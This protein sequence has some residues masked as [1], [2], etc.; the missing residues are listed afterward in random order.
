MIRHQRQA[1]I[2]FT[3]LILPAMVIFGCGG[4]NNTPT[5]SPTCM[6]FTPAQAPAAGFV[7]PQVDAASTCDILVLNMMVTDVDDLFGGGALLSF[8]TNLM[9]YT[10]ISSTGSTLLQ[11]GVAVEVAGDRPCPDAGDNWCRPL[12]QFFGEVTIGI[13]RFSGVAPGVNVGAAPERLLRL[14]FT[15]GTGEG[16]TTLSFPSDTN[17]FNSQIPPNNVIQPAPVWVGGTVT[18]N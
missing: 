14:T 8:P 12:G 7:A 17:L 16:T 6:T 18:V 15:K 9:N 1:L 10:G 2:L 13:S 11:N 3:T 4:S 5:S